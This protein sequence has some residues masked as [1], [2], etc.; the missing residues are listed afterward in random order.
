MKNNGVGFGGIAWGIGLGTSPGILEEIPLEDPAP[1]AQW[2][3]TVVPPEAHGEAELEDE[4]TYKT[5]PFEFPVTGWQDI[6]ATPNAAC[7]PNAIRVIT[8]F[9]TPWLTDEE[10]L[11][12]GF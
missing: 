10:D 12:V 1:Y 4:G 7:H 2:Q 5:M 11:G 3:A 6:P 9:P 8:G